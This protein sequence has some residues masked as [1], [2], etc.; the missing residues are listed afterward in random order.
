MDAKKATA[1]SKPAAKIATPKTP[2]ANAAE[3][4]IV[5]VNDPKDARP[6]LAVLEE[7]VESH[8]AEG[9]KHWQQAAVALHEIKTRKLWKSATGADGFGYANFSDYAER[10]FGF[11]K[12]YAYDLAKA[13]ES[14]KLG[15]GTERAARAA[16]TEERD[17]SLTREKAMR[18]ILT[19]WDK[20]ADRAGD[21][22]D[23][24]IDDEDF[25]AAYD[26]TF[27][28]IEALIRNLADRMTPI[29]GEATDADEA[30]DDADDDD[31]A[32]ANA[33]DDADDDGE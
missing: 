2:E 6:T 3:K 21:L 8:A 13:A 7:R 1:T 20:F 14:G 10:R 22:R 23:R 32:D 26:G 9:F 25:T 29:E 16:R 12:T 15:E 18:M 30:D 24:A 31:A 17:N 4:G 27:A 19:A 33:D 28:A 11:K 5:P